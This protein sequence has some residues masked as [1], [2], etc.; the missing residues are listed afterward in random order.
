M[1]NVIC[2]K[3]KPTTELIERSSKTDIKGKSIEIKSTTEY[4]KKPENKPEP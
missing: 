4:E 1:G 2:P 3:G